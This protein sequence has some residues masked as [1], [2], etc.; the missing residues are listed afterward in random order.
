MQLT[1]RRVRFI[2]ETRPLVFVQRAE[3]PELADTVAAAG[4]TEVFRGPQGRLLVPGGTH[5]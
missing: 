4:Y 5:G 2:E 3:Q 1:P